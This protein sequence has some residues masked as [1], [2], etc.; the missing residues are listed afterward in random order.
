M[1][2]SILVGNELS[3]LES[4]GIISQIIIA[5]LSLLFGIYIFRENSKL[6]RKNKNFNIM[7]SLIYQNNL[8]YIFEFY[9][10]LLKIT[11]KLQSKDISLD[12]KREMDSEI[13]VEVKDVR[14]NFYDLFLELNSELYLNVKNEVADLHGLLIS[15]IFNDNRNFSDGVAYEEYIQNEISKSRSKVLG[16][17]AKEY[18]G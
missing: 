14:M 9:S 18:N 10:K 6:N 8:K 16:F 12:E 2:V 13:F 5:M 15:E 11:K 1:L 7:Y 3:L 17:I 4:L